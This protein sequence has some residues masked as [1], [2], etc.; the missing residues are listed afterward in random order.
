[1]CFE[2]TLSTTAGA[3]ALPRPIRDDGFPDVEHYN[4]ELANLGNP[5]WLNVQWLYS[6]CYLFR[7]DTIYLDQTLT[8][9]L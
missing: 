6:E 8:I 4:K 2:T 3:N 9:A 1:M 5:S 7:Y